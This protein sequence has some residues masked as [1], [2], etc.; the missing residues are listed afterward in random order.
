MR[1][2]AKAQESRVAESALNDDD[3][4]TISPVFHQRCNLDR[5]HLTLTP[6]NVAIFIQRARAHKIGE[7]TEMKRHRRITDY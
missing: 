5:P 4:S 7:V 1:H 2:P 3:E 6:P